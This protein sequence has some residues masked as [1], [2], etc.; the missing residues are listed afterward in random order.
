MAYGTQLYLQ[1]WKNFTMRKREKVRFIV[2]IFWP[3]FLFLILAWVR[4]TTPPEH[5]SDCHFSVQAMPSAGLIPWFQSLVCSPTTDCRFRNGT[6]A[7]DGV[8][9]FH[10]SLHSDSFLD[11]PLIWRTVMPAILF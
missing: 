3:L 6:P 2:E 8:N 7:G 9:D 4:H 5:Q 1:L 10:H 11:I